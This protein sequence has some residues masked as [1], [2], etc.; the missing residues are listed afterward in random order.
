MIYFLR[1]LLGLLSIEE[2]QSDLLCKVND[3]YAIVYWI[4]S[5]NR[6]P[7][8]YNEVQK[9]KQA[10]YSIDKYTSK[11]SI[12]AIENALDSCISLEELW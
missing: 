9:I 2:I 1:K 7:N 6:I 8:Y 12:K 10:I 5:K 11:K 3:Y 4:E